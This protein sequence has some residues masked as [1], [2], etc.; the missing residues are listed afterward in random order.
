MFAVW[1]MCM[2]KSNYLM[3]YNV[4]T[5]NRSSR[6]SDIFFHYVSEIDLFN[7]KYN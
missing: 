1:N 2:A 4:Y 5:I 7:L 3:F 6:S